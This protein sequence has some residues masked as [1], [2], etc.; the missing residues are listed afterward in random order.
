VN[1]LANGYYM[2][3]AFFVKGCKTIALKNRVF[4][5]AHRSLTDL[6]TRAIRL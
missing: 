5:C 4:V 1:V 2:H 3:F 6:H